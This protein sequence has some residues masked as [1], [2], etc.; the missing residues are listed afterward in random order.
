MKVVEK[1]PQNVN[2]LLVII[3]SFFLGFLVRIWRLDYGLPHFIFM[4]EGL[5]IYY[6]MNM[7]STFSPETFL[8]PTLFFY[9]LFAVDVIYIVFLKISG[10]IASFGEAWEFYKLDRTPFYVLGRFLS[11]VTGTLTAGVVYKLGGLLVSKRAAILSAIFLL[12]SFIHVQY[13]HSAYLDITLTFLVMCTIYFGAKASQFGRDRDFT[14]VGLLAGL[15]IALKYNGGIVVVVAPIAAT[16]CLVKSDDESRLRVFLRRMV[17]FSIACV[18]GFTIGTP[19]WILDFPRFFEDMS[20]FLGFYAPGIEGH[21]HLGFEGDWNWF[22]YLLKPLLY[23]L[24]LPL[25]LMGI[26]GVLYTAVKH[27][28]MF[29]VVFICPLAYLL[30]I[31]A[32]EIRTARYALPLVPFMCLAA[33]I[34]VDSIVEIA[35]N[36][37]KRVLIS[38]CLLILVPNILN[39]TYYSYLRSV[40]D[41]RELMHA[42]V[43]ENISTEAKVGQSLY[44]VIHNRGKHSGYPFADRFDKTIFDTR[45]RNM[46][47]VKSVSAYKQNGYDY[48]LIDEW[49]VG[50][51]LNAPK[52]RKKHQAAAD[53]YEIFL[54]DLEKNTSLVAVFSPYRSEHLPEFDSENVEYARRYLWRRKSLGP[55]LKIYKL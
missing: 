19:Y 32:V 44:G 33:A 16:L 52:Y 27:T 21:G 53:Q 50:T 20:I 2:A 17:L 3:A 13:S 37:K 23:G 31:G 29:F 30:F 54:K 10:T 14:F 36:Y 11:A 26:L 12:F 55:A 4:D 47:G 8:K 49:H 46:S 41:T 6:G 1:S 35:K 38:L 25:W 9:L 39:L 5:H 51:V 18:A 22:Y 48:I 42:W 34:F 43:K 7:G 28:R 40:P 24:H 15:T 45:K